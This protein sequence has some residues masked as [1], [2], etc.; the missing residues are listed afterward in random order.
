MR[1]FWSPLPRWPPA[2][3]G[4]ILGQRLLE[5][6]D[7]RSAARDGRAGAGMGLDAGVEVIDDRAEVRR[8][9]ACR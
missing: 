7:L 8:Y 5:E 4:S 3:G 1:W 6:R 9:Q 2:L